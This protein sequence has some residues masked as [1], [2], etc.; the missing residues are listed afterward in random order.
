[1]RIYILR[2]ALIGLGLFAASVQAEPLTVLTVR[3]HAVELGFPVEAVVEAVQQTTVG[4]QLPGR[5]VAVSADVGQA[6]KKGEV[7]MRLDAREAAE[8]VRAAEAQYAN[9]KVNFERTKSLVAQKFMSAAALDKAKADF[10]AAS[11]SRAAAGVSQSHATIVAPIAGI[12][13]RRHAELGDMAMPGTPLFTIFQPGGLRVTASIPQYRLNEMRGVRTARVEFP[14]LGKWVEATAVQLLPTADAATHVSQ[15]RVV[16]PP[17]PEARPGMFV[18]A[19]FVTGQGEKLT[20]PATAVWRRG[21]VATVYVQGADGR[22]SL[23]QLRLGD[24]VGQGE[25][26]VLAGL[27]AGD[28][29]VTDP[30]KAAIALKAAPAAGR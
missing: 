10:D 22:L 11:A 23:R 9:A 5:I 28:K 13:A 17:M 29:V 24:A 30:V 16:L 19:H 7:L 2:A 27:A 21:E 8:A 6:V 20:V 15:V 12:V 26:E 1:M 25:I 3:P 18:R 4:A 14:E